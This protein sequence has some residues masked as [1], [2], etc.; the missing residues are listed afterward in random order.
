MLRFSFAPTE[1][2][3]AGRG[4]ARGSRPVRRCPRPQP[5]P[6]AEPPSAASG[7]SLPAALVRPASRPHRKSAAEPPLAAER[8]GRAAARRPGEPPGGGAVS[9]ET[10]APTARESPGEGPPSGPPPGID[11]RRAGPPGVRRGA[12]PRPG[13]R[14]AAVRGRRGAQRLRARPGQPAADRL[15][16]GQS[17]LREPRLRLDR[18]RPADLL[19]D[20]E[21]LARPA[22]RHDG[23]VRE[24]DA[25]DGHLRCSTT[26][27]WSAS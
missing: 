3:T 25:P 4:P 12:G 17:R 13:R 7:P 6:A 15:R 5:R 18:L 20:L 11:R 19:G 23:R 22:L 27:C 8:G 26:R 9:R 10:D 21:G 2:A 1:D 24:V 16:R 14:P